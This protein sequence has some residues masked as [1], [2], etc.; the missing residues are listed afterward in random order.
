MKMK[1]HYTKFR[2]KYCSH[3]STLFVIVTIICENVILFIFWTT[4]VI[5]HIGAGEGVVAGL[6][7][8]AGCQLV[9][10]VLGCQAQKWAHVTRNKTVR[11]VRP[12]ADNIWQVWPGCYIW[13]QSRPHWLSGCADGVVRLLKG[14]GL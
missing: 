4:F 9:I 8:S 14:G 13:Y 5:S 6:I 1:F 3:V 7:K 12:K 11:V 2:T 10:H